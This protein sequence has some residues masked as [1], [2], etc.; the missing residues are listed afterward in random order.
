MNLPI[1]RK[2]QFILSRLLL[3]SLSLR[4]LPEEAVHLRRHTTSLSGVYRL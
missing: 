4:S 1:N 3:A 2:E